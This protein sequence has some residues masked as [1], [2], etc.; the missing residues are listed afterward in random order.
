MLWGRQKLTSEFGI[1]AAGRQ[2]LF[3]V[4]EDDGDTGYLYLYEPGGREVFG[5]LHVYDRN[6]NLPVQEGDVR[7]LW[8]DDLSKVGVLIWGKMR[9]IVNVVTGQEGRVWLENRNTP[10]I[11][12]TEWLKGFRI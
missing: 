4:F 1:E 9:G 3:G 10:G 6:P 11:G 8:S 2:G 7:V 5:H 12:D